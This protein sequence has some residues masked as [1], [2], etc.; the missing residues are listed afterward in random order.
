[1][2]IRSGISLTKV[3]SVFAVALVIASGCTTKSKAKTEAKAAYLEGQH[4][5]MVESQ[6]LQRTTVRF[7]GR[8]QHPFVE[9]NPSLTLTEAIIVADYQGR[10]PTQIIIYRRGQPQF[11]DPKALLA[12]DDVALMPGDTVELRP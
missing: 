5:G 12:G 9:W 7:I 2:T 1:M 3:L 6:E 10:E 4:Q 8:V 11:V